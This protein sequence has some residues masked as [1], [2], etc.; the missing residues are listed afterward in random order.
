MDFKRI[1]LIFLCAF[2]SLNIFLAYTY[3]QSLVEA[4]PASEASNVIGI[5]NRLK[6]DKISF[7]QEFSEETSEGYYLSAEM[8]DFKKE[9]DNLSGDHVDNQRLSRV[10]QPGSEPI[11]NRDTIEKDLALFVT[12]DKRVIAGPDYTYLNKKVSSPGKYV[13]TQKYEGLPFND[14]TSELVIEVKDTGK[15]K[16]AVTHIEQTHLTE[17]D[18]LREKQEV[19][20][21]STAIETLYKSNRIPSEA[22]ILQTQLA[23]TRIFTVRGKNVYIPAWFVWIE[24]NKKNVQVERINAFSNSIISAN[25]PEVKK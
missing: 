8:T 17:I 4:V 23:Y 16:L 14:E 20:S 7:D 10:M 6:A 24:S 19:I 18:S 25:V 13:F 11:V 12:K 9:A 5:E 3:T 22:K 15:S 21:E 2:L 1:E